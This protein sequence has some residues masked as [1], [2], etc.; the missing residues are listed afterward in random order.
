MY[1]CIHMY[2]YIYIYTQVVYTCGMDWAIASL[3]PNPY[4]KCEQPFLAP[5]R[6]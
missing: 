2:I 4:H 6:G 5:F 1:I 3:W